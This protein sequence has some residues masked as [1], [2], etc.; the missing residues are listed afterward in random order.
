MSSDTIR[1]FEKMTEIKNELENLYRPLS[2]V[3]GTTQ[4]I[5]DE[6]DGM[7]EPN[8]NDYYEQ[9]L[10]KVISNC[11]EVNIKLNSLQK[12]IYLL[13]LTSKEEHEELVEH[14]RQESGE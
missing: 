8:S 14:A 5:F 7:G 10:K 4:K 3:R 12:K 6:V 9:D 11:N 13:W 2:D 1:R